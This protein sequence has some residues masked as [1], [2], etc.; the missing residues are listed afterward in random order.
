MCEYT[1]ESYGNDVFHS[2]RQFF[3]NAKIL[4][5]TDGTYDFYVNIMLLLMNQIIT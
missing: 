1:P 2:V 5:Y 3:P 4:S